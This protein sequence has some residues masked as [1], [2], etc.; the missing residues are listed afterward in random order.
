MNISIKNESNF[1]IQRQCG[2]Y[3][4]RCLL[5]NRIY[6]GSTKQNFRARFSNHCKFLNQGKLCNNLLQ[7]DYNIYGALNF[8]FEILSIVTDEKSTVKLEQEFI[9]ILNP[10]Y[11][12]CKTATNNSRTNLNKKFTQEHKDKI[13]AKSLLFKHSNIDKISEQNKK[14]ASNFKVT[15]LI[16]NTITIVKSRLELLKILNITDPSKYYNKQYKNWFIEVIKKQKKSIILIIDNK[17]VIFNSY[18]KCD[19]F[20]NKWRGY[21]STQSLKN[22]NTLCGYNVKFNS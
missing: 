12:I 3:L 18:E 22:V 13:R 9:N 19:K 14:G 10:Y 1:N 2:I 4:I 21:T 17:E 8:E 7:N 6:V 11:N 20:L 16:N 15:N 5:N